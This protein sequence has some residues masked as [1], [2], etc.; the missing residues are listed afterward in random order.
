MQAPRAMR[1][2][3]PALLLLHALLCAAPAAAQTP[4]RPSGQA[5]PGVGADDPRAIIDRHLAPWRSLGRVEADLGRATSF[6]TGA[7]I[8]PRTVLTAAH[9][10]T[11][12]D[13]RPVAPSAVRFRLGYHLGQS[14]ADARVSAMAVATAWRADGPAGTDWAVLTLD[15]AIASGDRILPVSRGTLQ[16]RTPLM[17]GG[18][19]RDNP[20]RIQADTACR[21]LGE[22]VIDGIP[23]LVHDCAS[24][25]GSSGG[26]VLA[27][28]SGGGWVVVGVASRVARDLALG[29]AVPVAAVTAR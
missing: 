27:Q 2:L 13:G 25:H 4:P 8:G 22:Q 5:N 28:G 17:L 7:L 16:A 12:R 20:E 11:G 1:P 26:P 9:C 15:A 3:R 10:V 19:Q 23:A 21:A 24:T 29:Q 18:Y 14:V 6:C